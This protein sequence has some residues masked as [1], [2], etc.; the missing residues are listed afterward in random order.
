[1]PPTELRTSSHVTRFGSLDGRVDQT[2]SARDGVEEELCGRETGE[3]TV[4][5]ESL[6]WRVLGLLSEVGQGA[7][8]ETI[9]DTATRDNLLTDTGD[10]LGDVDD[11]TCGGLGQRCW[12]TI[13]SPT[14]LLNHT[15]P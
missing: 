9:G 4:A 5:D 1:M 12:T 6:R 13:T 10:H 11:G 14:H 8:L 2:F 15:S 7:V 3:E